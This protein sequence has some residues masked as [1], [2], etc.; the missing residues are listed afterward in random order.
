MFILHKEHFCWRQSKYY[1]KNQ[2]HAALTHDLHLNMHLRLAPFTLFI[3]AT[4][5]SNKD[6][7]LFFMKKCTMVQLYIYTIVLVVIPQWA[8]AWLFQMQTTYGIFPVDCLSWVRKYTGKIIS[9]FLS[10]KG[11]HSALVRCQWYTV[12]SVQLHWFSEL[13][14]FSSLMLER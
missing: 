6:K 1:R 11:I 14:Y 4:F 12:A 5:M 13:Y 7:L 8:I 3:A 2:D 10:D 9:Y